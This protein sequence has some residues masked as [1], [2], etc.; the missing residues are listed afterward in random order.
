MLEKITEDLVHLHLELPANNLV[1]WT[2][3]SASV[4]DP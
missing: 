3:G 1:A 4:R 2:S